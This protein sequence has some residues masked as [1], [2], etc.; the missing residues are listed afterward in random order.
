MTR[1]IKFRAWD[2]ENKEMFFT[3]DMESELSIDVNRKTGGIRFYGEGPDNDFTG[4]VWQEVDCEIMQFTGLK[5]MNGKE[6]F[7]GDI[8]K[9]AG[10]YAAE[11]CGSSLN[12]VGDLIYIEH[13]KAR[14]PTCV[15][16]NSIP[17]YLACRSC[18]VLHH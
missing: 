6:I 1:E 12:L 9:A 17:K 10:E 13:F 14:M 7:E 11:I 15:I 16:K 4:P 5:D 3:Q 8:V 18:G 2:K